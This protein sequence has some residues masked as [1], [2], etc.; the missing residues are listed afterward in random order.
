MNL[1][2]IKDVFELLSYV[3]V[4]LGVPVGIWQYR[5]V[6]VREQEER[7]LEREARAWEVYN[8]LDDKYYDFLNLCLAYPELDI[9]DLPD[10]PAATPAT[11]QQKRESI[12]FTMLISLFERA[13]LMYA[14]EENV[15][16]KSQWAGWQSY[17][18]D[19]CGRDSFVRTWKLAGSSY[20]LQFQAYMNEQLT[21]VGRRGTST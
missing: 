8:S 14:R 2:A 5:Q 16:K 10:D 18:R 15:F 19:Y 20:D 17:I 11:Q 7:R 12:A 6:K 21:A 3:V 13:F 4:V 9:Y 1:Q